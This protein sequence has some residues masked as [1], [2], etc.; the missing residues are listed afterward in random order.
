MSDIHRKCPNCKEW[1]FFGAQYIPDH[2]CAPA[3]ECRLGWQDDDD[4]QIVHA[5]EP[6][7]AAEKYAERYDCEGGEYVI[8]SQ[9]CDNPIVLVRKIGAETSER[10]AI[11]AESVPHYRAHALT[12]AR[13]P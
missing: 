4:W 1:G 12:G 2:K 3:W 11:E 9:C 8:V 5:Q 7:D 10:W 6:K 13:K